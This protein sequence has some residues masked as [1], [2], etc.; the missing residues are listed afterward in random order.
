MSPC[1]L[2]DPSPADGTARDLFAPAMEY[3]VAIA[4]CG[5]GDALPDVAHLELY[6]YEF[7]ERCRELEGEEGTWRIPFWPAC[8]FEAAEITVHAGRELERM[9]PTFESVVLASRPAPILD[10]EAARVLGELRFD[11]HR[12]LELVVAHGRTAGW[13]VRS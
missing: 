8:L 3:S 6:A 5:S 11:V 13:E 12:Y 2:I 7:V 9:L 1:L 4:G 10:R